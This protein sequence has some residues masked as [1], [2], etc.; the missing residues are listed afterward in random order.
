MFPRY[1]IHS[2]VCLE[3]FNT[4]RIVRTIIRVLT[5]TERFIYINSKRSEMKTSYWSRHVFNLIVII[6]L[7]IPKMFE[8][9][10]PGPAAS[11]SYS[12]S[13]DTLHTT[14]CS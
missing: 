1:Y 4:A 2:S 5:K 6:L 3:R 7:W 12:H 14:M 10:T 11:L 13:E 9:A 8:K